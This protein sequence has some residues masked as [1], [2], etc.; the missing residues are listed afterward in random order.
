M[1][2]RSDELLARAHESLAAARTVMAGAFPT[3]LVTAAQ[4]AQA[5]REAS[6]YGAQRFHLSGAERPWRRPSVS[7]RR[8]R[9]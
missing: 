9:R 6:D 4:R 7:S 1:S 5:Q 8:W 3:D 2:P